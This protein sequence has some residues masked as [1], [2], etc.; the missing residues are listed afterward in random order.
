[1]FTEGVASF[2]RSIALNPENAEGFAGKAITLFHLGR[3]DEARTSFRK[4]IDIDPDFGNPTYL[5]DRANWSAKQLAAAKAVL[6]G[7]E[8]KK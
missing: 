8:R 6:D 2:E 1:M 7:L 4:S 5:R 3:E